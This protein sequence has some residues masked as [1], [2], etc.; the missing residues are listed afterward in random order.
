MRLE[1]FKTCLSKIEGGCGFGFAGM[2]EPFQ[3]RDCAKMIRYAYEQGYKVSLLTTLCGMTDEDLDMIQDVKF[4]NVRLHIPDAEGNSK[5]VITQQYLELFQ[6]FSRKIELEGY[7]CHGHI[8]D[9]VKSFIDPDLT[10]HS[11][12]FNRAGNLEDEDLKSYNH[13]GR[14]ICGAATTQDMTGMALEILP[15]GAVALCCMDYNLD[16]ILGNI[17]S[18]DWNEIFEGSEYINIEK[19]LN[20]ESIPLLCRKCPLAVENSCLSVYRKTALLGE[21]AVKTARLL[22]GCGRLEGMD[23]YH[24]SIVRR[25]RCAKN[26]CIF[27]LGKLFRDNYWNSLW[28][29][30]IRANV[31]SDN[32]ES[33]WGRQE[34]RGIE[35]VSP[36]ELLKMED[37]LIVTYVTDD[38]EIRKQLVNKGLNNIINIFDIFDL[39]YYFG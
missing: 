37:L 39:N 1:D 14:I 4:A 33:K 29:N 5:F 27:G 9:A 10:V 28:S 3:N 11:T 30:V 15:N 8:H 21:N 32:D 34:Y 6:K 38:T 25:I 23:E 7:S 12:M 22:Q 35:C 20:D 26:I 36:D 16:H 17:I 24:A 19:G 31:F 18:Q 13:K 2:V